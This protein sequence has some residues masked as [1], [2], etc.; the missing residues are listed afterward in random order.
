MTNRQLIGSTSLLPAGQAVCG[1]AAGLLVGVGSGLGRWS[2]GGGDTGGMRPCAPRAISSSVSPRQSAGEAGPTGRMRQNVSTVSVTSVSPR[3]SSGE[4]APTLAGLERSKMLDPDFMV[5]KALGMGKG[6]K[7]TSL[8]PPLDPILTLFW[9]GVIFIKYYVTMVYENCFG[10]IDLFAFG[11]VSLKTLQAGGGGWMRRDRSRCSGSSM[12]SPLR[13]RSLSK[14]SQLANGV[15][16][17]AGSALDKICRINR[18][19]LPTFQ[20][21]EPPGWLV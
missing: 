12:E 15:G 4:V 9:I 20:A 8:G 10:E 1:Y 21:S 14:S 17:L 7:G 16:H 19:S 5:L 13:A 3:Q 2:G 18:L 11:Q 6:S